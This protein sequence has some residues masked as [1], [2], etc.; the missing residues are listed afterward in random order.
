[1]WPKRHDLT[2]DRLAGVR[3]GGKQAVGAGAAAVMT[4][5]RAG[6]RRSALIMSAAF[7]AIMI[8]GALV[9]PEVMACA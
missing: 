3:F 9:L 1:M 7:S 6:A 4:P 8:T 5:G 2:R